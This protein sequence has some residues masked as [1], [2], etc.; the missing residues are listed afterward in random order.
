MQFLS[1]GLHSSVRLIWDYCLRSELTRPRICIAHYCAFYIGGRVNCKVGCSNGGL[2][3]S[4]PS[5]PS[6]LGPTSPLAPLQ[7]QASSVQC[8]S[9]PTGS[10]QT[11]PGATQLITNIC[12]WQCQSEL[13]FPSFKSMCILNKPVMASIYAKHGSHRFWTSH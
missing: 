10:L 5:S 4:Q 6:G 9:P 11:L 1:K 7:F 2:A 3:S 12:C 8:S 13:E